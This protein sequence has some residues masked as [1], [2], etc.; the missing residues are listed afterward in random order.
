MNELPLF[1]W[2]PPEKLAIF[3]ST[4]NR[5]KILRT[6]MTAAASKNPGNTIRATV[7][8]LRSSLQ[9][10]GLPLALIE[11]DV[12]ELEDALRAQVEVL[13]SKRGVAK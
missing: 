12:A 7:D 6:A 2:R 9:R 8:R 1:D 3:P 4:R 5:S 13:Q 11:K 10:K